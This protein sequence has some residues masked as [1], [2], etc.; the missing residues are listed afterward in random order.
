MHAPCLQEDLMSTPTDLV[1]GF[2]GALGRR[3]FLAARKLLA[4]DFVFRGPFDTFRDPESYLEALKKLY[5][6][7]KRVK[8]QKLFT[9]GD[10]ACLLYEM[11]TNTPIGTAFVCEWF[12]IRGEA[13]ISIRAV[14]DARPFAP[15]FS[16]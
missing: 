4:S 7:V 1:N 14:F 6:I 13:I 9:D 8:P 5:P 15:M 11:E 3:D 16:Q 10:D 12:K 2:I